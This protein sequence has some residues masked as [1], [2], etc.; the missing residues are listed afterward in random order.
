[1]PGFLYAIYKLIIHR[2][3]TLPIVISVS[4][5]TLIVMLG[6]ISEQVAMLRM[7]QIDRGT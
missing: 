1:L 7:G 4:V 2:P 3:W 6:L 5:G